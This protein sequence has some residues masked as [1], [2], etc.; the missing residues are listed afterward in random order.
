M[1]FGNFF[2]RL[3]ANRF[4]MHSIKGTLCLIAFFVASLGLTGCDALKALT[5]ANQTANKPPQ[6]SSNT[7]TPPAQ[8]PRALPGKMTGYWKLAY[9]VNNDVKSSHLNLEQQGDSFS[10]SGTDDHNNKAFVIENGHTQN[11]EVVFYKRYENPDS[12]GQPPVAY[13]G[14]I[15]TQQGLGY[16][17]GKYSVTLQGK[18]FEG[19]WE[20]EQEQ[21]ASAPEDKAAQQAPPPSQGPPDGR[22]PDLSGKWNAGFEHNFD[23]VHSTMFLEQH[24]VKS[25]K[26]PNIKGHGF[27]HN[28]NEK[29]LIE[30]GYYNY[31]AITI[32]RKYPEVK[33]KNKVVKPARTMTFK[34]QVEWINDKD[35]T[36]P[37]MSGKTEGGGGWE[38]QLVR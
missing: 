9:T 24:S 1:L 3:K 18:Q 37:Y 13:V 17:S 2:T 15:N 33:V 6:T 16:M 20:A 30:K 21:A 29:F 19:Q 35:Y 32:Y 28:T 8:Q 36:G 25:G 34:A 31:P 22:P 11:N 38:A 12:P 23:T 26:E 14:N 5:G 7:N 10:G 27:D 4:K